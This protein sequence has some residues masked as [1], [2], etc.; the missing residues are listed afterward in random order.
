MKY[1]EFLNDGYAGE[2]IAVTTLPDASGDSFRSGAVA[3][4]LLL[5]SELIEIIKQKKYQYR[6]RQIQFTYQ[7]SPASFYAFIQIQPA[8]FRLA[9]SNLI[10]NAVCA[11]ATHNNQRG[12][13]CVLLELRE[14]HAEITVADT[15]S[16]RHPVPLTFPLAD[17]PQWMA[18]MLVV[19]PDDIIIILDDDPDMHEAWASY[20]EHT[21]DLLHEIKIKHYTSCA[22]ALLYMQTL[23]T[24]ERHRVLM[25]TNDELISLEFNGSIVI[26]CTLPTKT[27]LVASDY[28]NSHSLQRAV[29][30]YLKTLPKRWADEIPI[31]IQ[32]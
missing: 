24:Q 29:R 30:R 3:V 6:H 20:F 13:I 5:S 15:G 22:D 9:I 1:L 11:I 28:A 2:R 26:D 7:F 23:S 16:D 14:Q 27:L 12:Q 21:L 17:A 18:D 8:A 19:N 10:D 4:P 32:C 25:V 31:Y